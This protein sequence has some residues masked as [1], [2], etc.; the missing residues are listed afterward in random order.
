MCPM[1]IR[2]YVDFSVRWFGVPQQFQKSDRVL[3]VGGLGL[4]EHWLLHLLPN[5]AENG[6]TV[7][8]ILLNR[9]LNWSIGCAPRATVS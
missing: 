6:Y 9:H 3:P 2:N 5:C 4:H 1:V 7:Q 8:P